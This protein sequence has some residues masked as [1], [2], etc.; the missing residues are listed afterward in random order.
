MKDFKNISILSNQ[1]LYKIISIIKN[2]IPINKI[3]KKT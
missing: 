1:N 2:I 3:S